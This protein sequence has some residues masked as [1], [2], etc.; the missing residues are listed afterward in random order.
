MWS[1]KGDGPD[2]AKVVV[3]GEKIVPW[4]VPEAEVVEDGEAGFG[5]GAEKTT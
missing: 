4:V 1:W 3:E 5:D 2:G